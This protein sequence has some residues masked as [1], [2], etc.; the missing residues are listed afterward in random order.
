MKSVVIKGL[1]TSYACGPFTVV[2]KFTYY[3]LHF[4]F[5][6]ATKGFTSDRAHRVGPAGSDLHPGL[7]PQRPYSRSQFQQSLLM[8]TVIKS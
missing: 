8:A 4:R 7:G 3:F 6:D 5:S 1:V 2:V